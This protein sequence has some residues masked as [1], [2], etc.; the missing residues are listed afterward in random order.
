MVLDLHLVEPTSD[1][2][3]DDDDE[4]E[5]EVTIFPPTSPTVV[6]FFCLC[7]PELWHHN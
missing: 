2:D 4:N 7:L 5:Q 3:D 6:G 1:D